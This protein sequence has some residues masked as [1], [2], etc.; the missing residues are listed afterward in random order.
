MKT[1]IIIF[2]TLISAVSGDTLVVGGRSLTAEEDFRESED[3]IVDCILEFQKNPFG[4]DTDSLLEIMFKWVD[5]AP[6]IKLSPATYY[7]PGFF[8]KRNKYPY[9]V[10]MFWGFTYGQL[11]YILEHRGRFRK[12]EMVYS[13]FESMLR[14]YKNMKIIKR[15]A[16]SGYFDRYEEIHRNGK[17]EDFIEKRDRHL[18]RASGD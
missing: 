4:S 17:L 10:K 8:L 3:F 7:M 15:D 6:Y 9:Y 1:F 14:V 18:C 12:E 2:V 5:C 13:G 16:R 11:L